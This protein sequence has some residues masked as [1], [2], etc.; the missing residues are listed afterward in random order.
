M[1]QG[2]PLSGAFEVARDLA[3]HGLP[4]FP[5]HHVIDGR[6]S[7]GDAGCGS[8]GKHPRTGDGFKSATTDERILL[9][10]D[11]KFP[12]AN[13]ALA[14]GNR[15]AVVDIDPKTGADP[16]EIIHEYGLT[17]PTVWTGEALTGDLA[18]TRGAHVYCQN[19]IPTGAS[20]VPGV[21]IR[22]A[23]AYVVLPGSRH[24]SGVVYEWR[25]AA[26]PWTVD[27]AAVPAALVPT[28]TTGAA[29]P[30]GDI[31]RA[32]HR[33]QTLTS[34]AGTMRRRGMGEGEIVAA[35]LVT[36]RERCHPPLDD[37]HVRKVARSIARYSPTQPPPM[38][39]SDDRYN[40]RRVDVAALLAEPDT[41]IP[42]RCGHF[43]ADGYLT[44]LA[45][46]GGEGKSWLALALALGVSTGT[47]QAGISC[48]RG[49][50][51]IFDAENG[52]DL[53]RRRLRSAGVTDGVGIVLV[54][55][56]DI[57][58]DA[59]WFAAAIREEKAD[60]VVFDS[61]RMLTSGRDEDK[62]GDM[63]QPLSTL[64][65]IARNTRAAIV[66]VHHRGKGTA[67]FRG[68]SVIVDQT[69]LLF[70]LGR[71]TGDPE[72]RTRRKL[73]TAKCRIDEEPEARWLAIVTDRAR[74]LV[75]V[76]PAEPYEPDGGGRPRDEHR[77]TVLGVLDDTPR[78]GRAIA[79]VLGLSE[80]TARRLL[81][82]LEDEGLANKRPLGWV[83]RCVT[84][85]GH[86]AGDAPVARDRIGAAS[87]PV[88]SASKRVGAIDDGLDDLGPEKPLDEFAEAKPAARCRC[89]RPLPATDDDG[90]SRCAQCGRRT[91][92]TP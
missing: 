70:A 31:I 8:P 77:D 53:L 79:R 38:S 10:W 41:V 28:P 91:G 74:G 13:W 50:A 3:G 60:L 30:V 66:L 35:L 65:R 37:E 76:N 58:K 25:D 15:V 9:R 81:H 75:T 48:R 33:D 47:E 84:H 51:L 27:L 67:D 36:N 64:R 11:H 73:K 61:L 89:D 26:R 85:R 55:G 72:Q 87:L 44:V 69:D 92:R 52:R 54:D 83:R 32:G 80:P 86:D 4:V 20:A 63:E 71:E 59:A 39:M 42:W 22:A 16:R 49:R 23:G 5:L 90:E 82:D 19:G 56:L 6:C 78:S 68:S 7:C 43:A 62:S 34:L 1:S 57:V 88:G 46:R 12:D 21:E 29:A 14:C 45:G 18:G 40:G 17:G 2:K 24:V